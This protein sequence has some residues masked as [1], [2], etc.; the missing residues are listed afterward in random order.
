MAVNLLTGA[1][2]TTTDLLLVIGDQTVTIAVLRQQLGE[3]RI[4]IDK[5][6]RHLFEQPEAPETKPVAHAP[7]G[8]YPSDIPAA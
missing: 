8:T 1:Q 6:S 3:A 7:F 2:I 4:E 5:I